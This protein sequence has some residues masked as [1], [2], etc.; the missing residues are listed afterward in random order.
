MLHS[1]NEQEQH[2]ELPV[3]GEWKAL[4]QEDEVNL[5]YILVTKIDVVLYKITEVIILCI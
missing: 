3:V 5:R 2:S 1:V 4:E